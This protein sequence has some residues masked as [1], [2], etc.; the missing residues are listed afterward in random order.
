MK[1]LLFMLIAAGPLAGCQFS[2]P[3][4]HPTA[5][6]T[7]QDQPGFHP[8][9]LLGPFADK[10][11]SVE[12]LSREANQRF[13]EKNYAAAI[14]LFEQILQQDPANASAHHRLAIIHDLNREYAKA[15]PHYLAALEALQTDAA[16]IGDLGYSY[17]LQNRLAEAQRYLERSHELDPTLPNVV[18]NLGILYA[19]QGSWAQSERMLSQVLTPD[20]VRAAMLQWGMP[21]GQTVSTPP[22]V[23]PGG[24]A[25]PQLGER[26]PPLDA[27]PQTIELMQQ[28][29][30]A[31]RLGELQR[32]QA[33]QQRQMREDYERQQA[34]MQGYPYD[35]EG[36]RLRAQM[37]QIDRSTLPD[38]SRTLVV[39]PDGSQSSPSQMTPQQGSTQYPPS[40]TSLPQYG[41]TQPS[42][43]TGFPANPVS[44][45]TQI[46][47][48]NPG[49]L[50][51][52]PSTSSTGQFQP[53]PIHRNLT[54]TQGLNPQLARQTPSGAGS[55]QQ[56]GGNAQTP[57]TVQPAF[58]PNQPGNPEHAHFETGQSAPGNMMTQGV[59]PTGGLATPPPLQSQSQPGTIGNVNA[60]DAAA[61]SAAIMG[62]G[63]GGGPMFPIAT[64]LTPQVSPGTGS[65]MNGAMYPEPERQ[66]PTDR[67]M[68]FNQSFHY[69]PDGAMQSQAQELRTGPNS[70]G[71][72]MPSVM[73]QTQDPATSGMPP[74]PWQSTA[75][76][77]SSALPTNPLAVYDQS[78]ADHDAQTQQ[79]LQ[80]TQGQGPMHYMIAP[81]SEINP[82]VSVV[83]GSQLMMNSPTGSSSNQA[84]SP[85]IGQP[86]SLA[87]PLN[88]P[89]GQQFPSAQQQFPAQGQQPPQSP[90][91][92]TG[93][94]LAP[95]PW[96]SV[97]S[98]NPQSQQPG[99]QQ[100]PGPQQGAA[101]PPSYNPQGTF[102][103]QSGYQPQTTSPTTPPATTGYPP[104]NP[105]PV[106]RPRP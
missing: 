68:D 1:R 59:T 21:P 103:S 20:E 81:T 84:T 94:Q 42:Q 91:Y 57:G 70:M 56:V 50:T 14:P 45:Q 54:G 43:T 7:R 71:Q 15:E 83:T 93:N 3:F 37:G 17:L 40:G 47:P 4:A 5:S 95:S 51:Q 90:Y 85:V 66:L 80:Q 48:G 9:R 78:R 98:M 73:T 105:G 24:S 26:T 61:R 39:G 76:T 65:M 6:D 31:G 96:D 64:P 67:L 18:N 106:I 35:P 28:L 36:E 75:V 53:A 104:T 86:A 100:E 30:E 11:P 22:A 58:G 12:E 44:Q 79:T 33:Q 99:F 102:P 60:F 49:I 8:D 34:A 16:I 2:N 19:Q 27:S 69:Q 25:Q 38:N 74:S 88:P 55:L 52:T 23:T 92:P 62:L 77:G 13:D 82:N 32:A 87:S 41:T 89:G 72:T 101:T 63:V 29:E 97:P 46:P 10:T